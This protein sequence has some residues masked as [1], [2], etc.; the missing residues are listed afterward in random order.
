MPLHN[1]SG[2]R[3][4]VLYNTDYDAELI[5]ATDVSAV[6]LSAQ[7]ITQAIAD[8]GLGVQL[9]GVHGDDIG[10]VL[11]RLRGEAPDLVFN[12]CE[13]LAGD[14]RNE[15]VVPALLDMV[16][17]PYTGTGPLALGMCLHTDRCKDILIARG[18]ATPPHRV[19]ADR[20]DLDRLRRGGQLDGL[21]YPY[22]VKL[23][24]EDAS[25]GIDAS[26][27][28]GDAAALAAR[29][30]ALM[31]THRQPVIAERYIAG[32]EIN[33]TLVGNRPPA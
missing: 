19:I 9:H 3:V 18:V 27:R 28:V 24:H 15:L 7:A 29:A 11:A 1:H 8:C 33:V 20:D 4:A 30:A 14:A 2:R 10:E 6:Q 22:F 25:I 32:R 16:R 5:A 17:L 13:S 12:L 31:D 26:N 23:A 21:D